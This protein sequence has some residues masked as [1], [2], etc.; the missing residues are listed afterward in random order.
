M[1]IK[2]GLIIFAIVFSLSGCSNSVR[3][4]KKESKLKQAAATNI[5]LGI[6][7]KTWPV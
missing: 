7:Y 1:N 5:Q 4:D 6:G 3:E 2:L